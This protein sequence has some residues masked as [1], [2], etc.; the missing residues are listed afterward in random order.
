MSLLKNRPKCREPKPIFSQSLYLTCT[1]ER[2]AQKCLATA[3]FFR[4]GVRLSNDVSSNN[5][6]SNNVLSNDVLSNNVLSNDILSN[7]IL[8]NDVRCFV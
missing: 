1:V 3:V 8:S 6:L 5:V 2:I 4:Y 7:N